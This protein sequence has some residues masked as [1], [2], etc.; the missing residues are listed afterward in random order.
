MRK[1]KMLGPEGSLSVAYS[2]DR[3][4][5]QQRADKYIIIEHSAG[6]AEPAFKLAGLGAEPG[7]A[8]AQRKFSRARA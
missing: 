2:A 7:S 5:S 4:N 6:T 8:I 3:I 1:C